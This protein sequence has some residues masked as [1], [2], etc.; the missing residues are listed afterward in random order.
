MQKVSHKHDFVIISLVCVKQMCF[1]SLN[2]SI[3]LKKI[4]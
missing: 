2:S 4:A 1:D 3:L